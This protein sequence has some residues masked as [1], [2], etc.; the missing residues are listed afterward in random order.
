MRKQNC[1]PIDKNSFHTYA[2]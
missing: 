1:N 2:C